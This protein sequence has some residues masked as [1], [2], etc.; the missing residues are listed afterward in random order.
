MLKQRQQADQWYWDIF[1]EACGSRC[2][3][4]NETAAELAVKGQKLERGHVIPW[5][6]MDVA[7][8]PDNKIPVCFRC[9]RKYGKKETPKTY[10]P[11]DYLE[12]FFVAIGQR[13]RPQ[14][15]VNT[16]NGSR[17]VIPSCDQ[18]E[19][20]QAI[21]WRTPENALSETVLTRSGNT[22]NSREADIAV[23][24]LIA[25][26]RDPKRTRPPCPNPPFAATKTLLTTLAA[27]HGSRFRI[28]GIGFFADR[29]WIMSG[30]EDRVTI[31]DSCW[32]QF[33]ANFDL[34]Y[35]KGVER[36][37]RIAEGKRRETEQRQR[38]AIA[39]KADRWEKFQR[40]TECSGITDEDRAFVDAARA[41]YGDPPRD[42]SAADMARSQDIW[43]REFYLRRQI[44]TAMLIVCEQWKKDDGEDS[45][46]R[47]KV[48]NA[49]SI[50]EQRQLHQSITDFFQKWL[51][52]R[53]HC[54]SHLTPKQR[55]EQF[56]DAGKA[57]W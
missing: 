24:E 55:R 18:A 7:E 1:V 30:Y 17:Y 39:E 2:A 23:A 45:Y 50:V 19:N 6:A 21:S 46:A 4:C 13:L 29:C 28:A 40:V 16:E 26:S 56:M 38:E 49:T 36:Q 34:F 20:K 3:V 47:E 5:R 14:I 9:N 44:L 52:D 15:S 35:S 43:T 48:A 57:W 31:G 42:V 11:A 33:A 25:A 27:N 32:Q 10:R 54:L 53:S 12:R 51:Q 8:A 22:Y 37:K 41:E